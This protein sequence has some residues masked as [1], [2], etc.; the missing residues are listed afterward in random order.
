MKRP[1]L[2]FYLILIV[3]LVSGQGCSNNILKNN[4]PYIKEITVSPEKVSGEEQFKLFVTIKNPTEIE[5]K[6]YILYNLDKNVFTSR[7]YYK[8]QRIPLE[9]IPSGNEKSYLIEF[10]VHKDAKT[11]L[12]PIGIFLFGEETAKQSLSY[13][14]KQIDI[15]SRA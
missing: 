2:I 12:S 3:F 1:T 6:P 15:V 8:E 4:N 10:Q 5:F 13:G 9:P 14:E 7:Y 11:G